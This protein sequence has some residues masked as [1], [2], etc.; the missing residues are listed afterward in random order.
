MKRYTLF[1][2]IF[3]L[4]YVNF[5]WSAGQV[6]PVLDF[7][8]ARTLGLAGAGKAVPTLT[9]VIFLNPAALGLAESQ[10]VSGT[11]DW[12]NHQDPAIASTAQRVL[13]A[14]IIDGKN[15]YAGAGIAFTRRPDLDLYHMVVAKKL[16]NWFSVGG[17]AKRFSVRPAY[18]TIAGS[19]VGYD[20]GLSIALNPG[21]LIPLVPVQLGVTMDNLV[22]FSG[23]EKYIGGRKLGVGARANLTDIL[24][25]MVDYTK[26]M[27]NT[28]RSFSS[29]SLAG[30]LSLGGGLFARG[31][32]QRMDMQ[33]WSVGGSWM[34]PKVGFSYGYMRRTGPT[35]NGF[36]HA[37][38]LDLYM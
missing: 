1:L 37:F 11:Y 28:S 7:Q 8:S 35:P 30:E 21:A 3:S 19:H 32:I 25:L 29:M 16:T 5:A 23:N 10:G 12:L 13:N 4:F 14:S 17:T 18:E 34:A 15:P 22:R 36:E 38:T 24:Y 33:A 2:F 20:G 26:N 6:S 27:G 9:D 31:G